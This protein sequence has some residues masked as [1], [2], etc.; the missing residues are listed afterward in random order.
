MTAESQSKSTKRTSP[1]RV[2]ES[3]SFLYGSNA[4][5]IEGLYAQYLSNPASVDGTWR[6]FFDALG[7][8]GLKPAQL[9][10]GP[11]WRSDNGHVAEPNELV[12]ALT[13]DWGKAE[14]RIATPAAARSEERRV[15]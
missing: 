1:T 10:Q 12:S 11:S 8:Q 13:G 4:A 15:G 7:E 14:K 2:L 9:G 5:F 3:T 6:A